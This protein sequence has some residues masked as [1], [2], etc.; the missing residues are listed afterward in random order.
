MNGWFGV[1]CRKHYPS[2]DLRE[3]LNGTQDMQGL[4]LNAFRKR[5]FQEQIGS[6][7]HREPQI[8]N[9]PAM[10]LVLVGADGTGKTT[11]LSL[12]Q[13]HFWGWVSNAY[14]GFGQYQTAPA[15]WAAKRSGRLSQVLFATLLFPI[16]LF[17]RR[18]ASS[19]RAKDQILAV[20]RLPMAPL[21]GD[22]GRFSQKL[23]R[24]VLP[25][26]HLLVALTGDPEVIF[27]RKPEGTFE[28]FL[29]NYTKAMALS[30]QRLAPYQVT[31][32]TTQS[33]DRSVDELLHAVF[34]CSAFAQRFLTAI[35]H[36]ADPRQ[37]T[38]T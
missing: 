1:Y 13:Q 36:S 38:S 33:L 22:N 2:D 28:G 10:S 6:R 34:S 15:R 9:S 14:M 4:P 32:D 19:R 25:R 35:K 12:M 5:Y 7:P 29:K 3:L 27:N 37:L 11:L 8:F 24:C 21:L 26:F 18:T 16:E 17:W 23:Y 20:D 30:S 31:I